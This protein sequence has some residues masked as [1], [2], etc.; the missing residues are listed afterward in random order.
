M[1]KLENINLPI[2]INPLD[3]GL[4]IDTN[5]YDEY[6]K[7]TLS[8]K[9]NIFIIKKFENHNEV[10]Y[11][12]NDILLIKFTD[13]NLFENKFIRTIDNKKFYFE[14]NKQILATKEIKSKFIAKLKKSK[15]LT[16]NFLTLDIETYVKDSILTVFCIG[17]YDGIK[18]Q[19]F[20]LNDYNSPEELILAAIRSIMIRKYN[21]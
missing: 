11:F 16:E 4:L 15:V 8:T 9:G 2:S 13:T 1:Q 14:N 17:I 5:R 10:E 18:T 21:K 12:K 19:T 3:Y 20:I 6:I 7:Y